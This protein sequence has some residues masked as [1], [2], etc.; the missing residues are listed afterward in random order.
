MLQAVA[1]L[2]SAKPRCIG[3][4]HIHCDVVRERR[5]PGKGAAIV[6]YAI[7]AVLVCAD[8][9]S[10]DP[11]LSASSKVARCRF[12]SFIVES[13]AVDDRAVL[14]Q[15]EEART[16][17]SVLRKRCDGAALHKAKAQLQHCVGDFS[18][19]VETG[20]EP[21]RIGK[22]SAEHIDSQSCIAGRRGIQDRMG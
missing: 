1:I 20:C 13:H 8:V 2:E 12:H 15:P 11:N 3:R 9:D 16:N 14:R 7:G 10:D 19:L 22:I 6:V 4:R 21:N 18:I 5:Q 17:I